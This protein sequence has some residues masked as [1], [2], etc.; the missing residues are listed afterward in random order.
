MGKIR[1]KD[2]SITTEC[3]YVG[4]SVSKLIRINSLIFSEDLPIPTQRTLEL[5][6]KVEQRIFSVK[7]FVPPEEEE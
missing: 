1:P 6:Y 5:D 3:F 2:T 7:D 4:A